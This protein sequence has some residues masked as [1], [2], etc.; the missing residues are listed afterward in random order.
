MKLEGA[1]FADVLADAQKQGYAETPPDLDI[2]GHDAQH[3]TGI[4]ASLAHG[5]PDR[6]AAVTQGIRRIS[7]I[8]VDRAAAV[9]HDQAA[10]IIEKIKPQQPQRH[11]VSVIGADPQLACARKCSP[12][13]ARGAMRRYHFA[14]VTRGFLTIATGREPGATTS[15][16]LDVAVPPWTN[17]AIAKP[18]CA[19]C[20]WSKNGNV[21]P[22][23]GISS[24]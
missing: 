14:A 12:C 18:A 5:L 23:D 9:C 11:R 24:R 16:V 3:K 10:R 19:L 4:L 21:V 7:W 8:D 20:A 1:D 2:D 22:M 13:S 15:A 6:T 17:H